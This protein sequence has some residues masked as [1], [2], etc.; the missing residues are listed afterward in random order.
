MVNFRMAN[1]QRG[2]LY[3]KGTKDAL[4]EFIHA[5]MTSDV[6]IQGL[7]LP[8]VNGG[9]IDSEI[10]IDFDESAKLDDDKY[11]FNTYL[12]NCGSIN[13][14]DFIELSKAFNVDVYVDVADPWGGIQHTLLIENGIVSKNEVKEFERE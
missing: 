12:S 8:A 3:L 7:S 1:W 13:V 4:A 2:D 6:S 5:A 11:I 14:E 9:Y 10:K